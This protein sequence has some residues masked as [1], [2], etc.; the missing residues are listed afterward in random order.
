MKDYVSVTSWMQYDHIKIHPTTDQGKL[1]LRFN[2]VHSKYFAFLLIYYK[3][4]K[5]IP[6][7]SEIFVLTDSFKT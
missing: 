4:L 1:L 6:I 2:L 7:S 3:T 5:N